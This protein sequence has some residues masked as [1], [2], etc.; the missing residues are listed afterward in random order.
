[1]GGCRMLT[2]CPTP[3]PFGLRLGPPHPRW[4]NLAQE[5]LGLRRLRFSRSF[6][7]LIPTFSLPPRPAHL[8]G[9]PSSYYGTLPYH[10]LRPRAE[11]IRSVGSTLSPDHCRRRTARP[12][13]CYALF[14]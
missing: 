7:L 3:T 5:P 13:S 8:A 12:V 1:M 9:A 10:L 2:A 4:I 6:S 14:K 11:Q